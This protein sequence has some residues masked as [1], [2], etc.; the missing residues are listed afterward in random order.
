MKFVPAAGQHSY[1]A[2]FTG[3][4]NALPSASAPYPFSVVSQ[5][6]HISTSQLV[7]SGVPGNYNLTVTIPSAPPAGAPTGNVLFFDTDNAGYVLGQAPLV[8]GTAGLSLLQQT[9]YPTGQDAGGI[10]S[11]DFNN[12]GYA[13]LAATVMD[14]L[15]ANV[16]GSVNI[17]LGH[18]DGSFTAAP[19][20]TTEA[21]PGSLVTAD[22]NGDGNADLAFASTI[23]GNITIL[24]GK[25]DGTFTQL[26][27]PLNGSFADVNGLAVGDFNGDGIG[28]LIS[29]NAFAR[30]VTVFLGKGDGT[31]TQQPQ[32]YATGDNPI[33]M[34]AGDFNNDGKLDLIINN[35]FANNGT[36]SPAPL[37]VLLGNGDGTFTPAADVVVGVGPEA[38][39]AADFNGDGK[40]DLAVANI[41]P[42]ATV[43]V[44][45]GKGDGTFTTSSTERADYIN[46]LS[47]GDFNG[48]GKVD[49]GL[50]AEVGSAS[51]VGNVA[52]SLGNGDGTFTSSVHT[53]TNGVPV[54]GVSPDFNGD[55]LSDIALTNE[56][57]GIT[58]LLTSAS[59]QS[60]ATVTGI[61]PVG[62]G[63]HYVQASYGG[64]AHYLSALSNLVGLTALPVP[65]TLQLSPNNASVSSGQA[66]T[67]TASV[68]PNLAQ[69]HN[70]SCTVT[71]TSNGINIGQGIV[72]NGVA[73][74]TTSS[75]SS[76]NNNITAQYAGDT[77]FLPSAATGTVNVTAT[78]AAVV[79]TSSLNPA[80]ALTAITFT[81]QLNGVSGGTIQ[82]GLNGQSLQLV[83]NAAGTASYTTAA[84]GPGSYPVTAA[85]FASVSALAVAA[86]PITEIVSYTV[87]PPAL[88][89]FALSGPGSF[90]FVTSGPGAASLQV[91]S[92]NGF[93]GSVS[94]SCGGNVPIYYTCGLSPSSATLAAGG[95]AGSALTLT[96]IRH[97][98]ALHVPTRPGE[99]E[100][101]RILITL[102]AL[103]L[104]SFAGVRRRARMLR[105]VSLSLLLIAVACGVTACGGDSA[106]PGT[107]PGPYALT[108]TATSNGATPVVHTLNVTANVIVPY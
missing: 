100:A 63:T 78:A 37:T 13:D 20:V 25:G 90:S 98:A 6:G 84:L 50:F 85:W 77:N 83:P 86:Q 54:E 31:F 94:L 14:S 91:S 66:V 15:G 18:G 104:V 102:A 97:T 69:D 21:F 79:L 4:H 19:T 49:L 16:P 71:F 30:K 8:A 1:K 46:G 40:L 73:T 107:P 34:V 39:V 75:L 38:L 92:L 7:A 12:D 33:Y 36:L 82:L 42:P 60:T 5:G 62:M 108:I 52:A 9:T 105:A 89:D 93:A 106:I 58:V 44:L 87:T 74:L 23:T 70:A 10:L 24:L 48:D 68:N 101:P 64:D 17:L 29:N 99:R 27:G 45:L 96:P 72:A 28:D 57:G 103:A 55:G 22:F 81:V 47:I 95:L 76:G 67:F 3:T 32:Q 80:P 41:Q 11:A 65:T 88:P 61:S 26:A 35:I 43:Q 53:L 59:G 2:V 51:A 56:Y